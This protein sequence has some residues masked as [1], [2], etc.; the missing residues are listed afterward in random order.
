VRKGFRK[1]RKDNIVI[2][3]SL[4]TLR[5]AFAIYYITLCINGRKLI[6]FG[7]PDPRG[8]SRQPKKFILNVENEKVSPPFEGG[9]A[10]AIDYLTYTRLI[11]RP[12]WLILF[13]LKITHNTALAEK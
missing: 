3:S 13:D 11:T 6:I 9:V 12:G 1:A 7:Y 4:R 10:G 8:H 2:L 5:K